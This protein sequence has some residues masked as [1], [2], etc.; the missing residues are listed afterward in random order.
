MFALAAAIQGPDK[1]VSFD[2]CLAT[3]QFE[4]IL[5]W[6]LAIIASYRSV[7]TS[8]N[9]CLS[10]GGLAHARAPP[11][12]IGETAIAGMARPSDCG[13]ALNDVQLNGTALS[14]RR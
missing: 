8:D 11:D 9:R 7:R 14:G 5:E 6:G 1:T 13:A 2:H 10:L 4:A 12:V 3:T